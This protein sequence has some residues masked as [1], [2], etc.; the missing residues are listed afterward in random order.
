MQIIPEWLQNNQKHIKQ[1][2]YFSSQIVLVVQIVL[3]LVIN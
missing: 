3:K 1:S 2:S